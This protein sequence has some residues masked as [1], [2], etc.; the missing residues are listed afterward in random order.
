ML[1]LN[2][3]KEM[4]TMERN[5]ILAF[6]FGMFLTTGLFAQGCA[7]DDKGDGGTDANK[8]VALTDVSLGT[9]GAPGTG[10]NVATGGSG[11]A[12]GT[13][14]VDGGLGIDGATAETMTV[15][16]LGTGSPIPSLERF[17][18]STLVEAGGQRLLFDMGRGNTIRLWQLQISLGTINAHFLTHLHSDHVNGLCDLWLSGWIQTPFGGRKTPFVVYGPSGTVSMT[19]HLWDAYSEDR[20]IR[21]ADEGNPLSG[22]EFDAHDFEAGLVY[23]Q[24]GVQV[25]AFEVNH[26]ALVKPAFGFSISYRGHKVV[27]SGDTIY[28]ENVEKEA[29]KVDLL[30]HEVAMIPQALIDKYPTYQAI[31]EHHIS[32]EK[33]G[34]LFAAAQPKQVAYSHVVLSGSPKDGIPYPTP[35]DVLAATATTYSGPVV[36]GADLMSFKIDG[37]GV[38]VIQ[39]PAK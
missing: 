29:N 13:G 1:R 8:D 25:S 21:L 15:T 26:G 28:N 5:S 3:G 22:I 38:T 4:E 16:L 32:P 23:D 7:G 39:P 27:L 30:I 12:I 20:R 33:A 18:P 11:G 6:G 14:G 36:V 35:A 19:E 24:N 31:L 17:G 2:S 9:G 34:E 37:T 10:G